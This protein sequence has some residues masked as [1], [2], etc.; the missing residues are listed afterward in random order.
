M[1]GG[2]ALDEYSLESQPQAPRLAGCLTI[3]CILLILSS[4]DCTVSNTRHTAFSCIP[5]RTNKG[6]CCITMVNHCELVPS[7]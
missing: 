7:N 2:L 6:C 1:A 4:C 5:G 3:H